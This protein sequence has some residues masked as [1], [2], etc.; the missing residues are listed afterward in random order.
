MNKTKRYLI[1]IVVGAI[2]LLIGVVLQDATGSQGVMAI[3][4]IPVSILWLYLFP[5]T[6]KD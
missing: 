1:L 5:L 2:F 3:T 6:K 4:M